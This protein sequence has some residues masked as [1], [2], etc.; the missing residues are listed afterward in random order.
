MNSRFNNALLKIF[1]WLGII[2]LCFSIQQHLFVIYNNPFFG[3]ASLS[4]KCVQYPCPA[5]R[6][7]S[8]ALSQMHKGSTSLYSFPFERGELKKRR[9]MKTMPKQLYI[10]QRASHF[11]GVIWVQFLVFER[12]DAYTVFYRI[13]SY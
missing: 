5:V 10:L 11:Y 8:Q 1:T 13:Q 12:R 2:A 6:S 3:C 4:L 7:S 9:T